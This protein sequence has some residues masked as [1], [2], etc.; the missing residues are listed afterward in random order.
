MAPPTL[1]DSVVEAASELY[2]AGVAAKE[3][4]AKALNQYNVRDQFQREV[5]FKEVCSILGS[6]GGV[7]AGK[8]APQRKLQLHFHFP[9]PGKTTA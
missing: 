2:K 1:R 6:R 3:A 8:L 5:L 4:V 7:R 9:R